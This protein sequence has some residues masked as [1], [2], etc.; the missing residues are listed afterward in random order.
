[1]SVAHARRRACLLLLGAALTAASSGAQQN[2]AP[3][4]ASLQGK[5]V[6]AGTAAPLEGITVIVAGGRTTVTDAAGRY[7]VVGVMP[8]AHIVTFRWLGYT[9]RVDTLNFDA[10]ASLTLDVAMRP[11]PIQLGLVHV[12]GASRTPER[13][14]DAPAAVVTAEPARVRDL[15]G[16]GQVPMLVG[17]L[18][19]VRTSQAGLYDFNLNT[20]GLQHTALEP[21]GRWCSSTD[22]TCR[23]RFSAT[24]IGPASPCSKTKRASRWCAARAPRSTA[25]MRSAASSPLPLPPCARRRARASTS[26]VASSPR[27]RPT[28][29]T[30]SSP[31]TS[32]W[33]C[34]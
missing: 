4:D 29:A 27:S 24:R 12:T 28:R 25:R 23:R 20:H 15:V 18:V 9:P 8:G 14:V 34:V 32:A 31:T 3:A 33:D 17:D 26:R 1:M 5:V 2:A 6:D 21:R 16:T 13:V 11:A 19:G 7:R 22:A 10:G 30:R